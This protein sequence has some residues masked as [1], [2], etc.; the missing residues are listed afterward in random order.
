MLLRSGKKIKSGNFDI[1]ENSEHE[2]FI[3]TL[4]IYFKNIKNLQIENTSS[5]IAL[6][7]EITNMMKYICKN[8]LI[9]KSKSYESLLSK[10]I[11][12]AKGL[13]NELKESIDKENKNHLYTRKQWNLIEEI[14][15]ELDIIIDKFLNL[16]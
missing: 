15:Q 12:R 1:Y 13:K 8:I 2:K 4:K 10:S 3:K 6:T 16:I 5:D 14:Y 9:L 7:I 11:I